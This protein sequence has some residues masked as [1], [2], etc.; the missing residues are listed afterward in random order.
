M[1]ERFQRLCSWSLRSG[2]AEALPA[3]A[4]EVVRGFRSAP[5]KRLI[6]RIP[7]A[8]AGQPAWEGMVSQVDPFET[9]DCGEMTSPSARNQVL[10]RSL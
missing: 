2:E 1:L 5:E 8:F 9:H 10:E 7:S 3:D 4:S 6:R